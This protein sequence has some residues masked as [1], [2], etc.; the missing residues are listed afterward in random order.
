MLRDAGAPAA[1]TCDRATVHTLEAC[2]PGF[3]VSPSP[4]GEQLYLTTR[5]G[6]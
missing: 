2:L 5:Q 4:N 1:A 3:E 6:S